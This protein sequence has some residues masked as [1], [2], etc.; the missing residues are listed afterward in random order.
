MK[1][2]LIKI[3]FVL[4]LVLAI[5]IM[6]VPKWIAKA[7]FKQI[8]D[9]TSILLNGY[10]YYGLT[11]LSI[12]YD[13]F[14][15]E[16]SEFDTSYVKGSEIVIN[17]TVKVKDSNT[18]VLKHDKGSITCN[19]LRV[20]VLDC[21]DSVF[22][23]YDGQYSHEEECELSPS[24]SNEIIQIGLEDAYSGH[25]GYRYNNPYE[26]TDLC[27]QAYDSNYY[28]GV[29]NGYYRKS[30]SEEAFEKA[31]HDNGCLKYNGRCVEMQR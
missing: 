14:E 1:K 5:G 19:V 3:I 29:Y 28:T 26:K 12:D 30:K 22:R 9:D 27:Y 13:T 25:Q 4:I 31:T 10:T 6:L 24:E 8:F 23:R 2:K 16:Y 20:N 18:L 11:Y 21:D 15:L 17:G 7:K